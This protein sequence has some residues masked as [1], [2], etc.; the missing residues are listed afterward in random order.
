MKRGFS[1]IEVLFAIVFLL[2][3]GVGV[4]AL[5]NAASRLIETTELK[6]MALSLNE[7]SVAYTALKKRTLGTAGFNALISCT[8]AVGTDCVRYVLCPATPGQECVISSQAGSVQVGSAKISFQPKVTFKA[9]PE[10]G[11]KLLVVATTSWGRGIQRQIISSQ[12]IE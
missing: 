1:L 4:T 7:Q 12:I 8:P 9:D 3:V 6:I 5:N 11:D 2:I 10:G